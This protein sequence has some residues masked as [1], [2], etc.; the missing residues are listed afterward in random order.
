MLFRS[1]ALADRMATP[2]DFGGIQRI[3]C[4]DLSVSNGL[5]VALGDGCLGVLSNAVYDSW[6]LKAGDTCDSMDA[7]TA[8]TLTDNLAF[9]CPRRMFGLT[10]THAMRT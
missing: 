6:L 8:F 1:D 7:R 2:S 10:Q 9:T 5:L 3:T 4:G